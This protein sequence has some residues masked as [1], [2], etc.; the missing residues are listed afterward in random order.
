MGNMWTEEHLIYSN[1]IDHKANCRLSTLLSLMQ[2][3]A[4]GNVEQMGGS[5]DEMLSRNMGWMLTTID[6]TCQI[7][8]KFND[9]IKISTWNKGTKGPLWLRDYKILD[10][11]NQEIAK[12]CTLWALVDIVKRKVLRPSAYPFDI[13]S[14]LEDS[15]GSIPDKMTIADD[16]LLHDAYS[17]T[18]R[19]SG[20][21]SNGH[22]NNARYA[23]ICMDALTVEELDNMTIQGFKIS[24]HHEAKMGEEIHIL[25]SDVI[26]GMIYFKGQST[27]GSCYFDACLRI[28]E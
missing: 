1:E 7:I 27:E 3:A 5:R 26:E 15:A 10:E 21:D 14:N 11:N 4:D 16:I 8:P 13:H 17:I 22:L 2:R 6:L 25:R 28:Q 20:I 19:Y 9:T 12:A 24:Y 18:V 23:D